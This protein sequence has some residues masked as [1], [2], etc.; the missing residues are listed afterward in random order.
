[1]AGKI[2]RQFIDDLLARTDIVEL[3]DARVNLKKAGK[4]YQACCPFHNEK[5]PS[6][7]VSQDKQFYHCFGCGANGNAIS[8]VMEYDKLDFVDAIEELAS[9][10]HLEV[11]REQ[12]HNNSERPPVSQEQK[13]SDYELMEQAA[14]YYQQQLRHHANSQLVIDYLKGRGLSGQTVK[15]YQIGYAPSEW[16]AL[17]QTLGKN[18]K[19]KQQLIELK[20]ATQ[21]D[22]GRTFDFFRDRLMFPIRDRRGRVIAFGGRIMGSDDN[23]PKYLNS[24]ETRVF[25]KGFEL[26]GFYEAKQAHKK[27]EQL[28]IVEGYMDVVALAEHDIKYAVAALGTAT[29]A[30]HM[31]LLLRATDKV[32]CC[33]DGDRAG[34]DAAWR[35]LEN[36][37][38]YLKDGK[39]LKFVFLPDG[40]D[41]DSLVQQEGKAAFEQRLGDAKD[42]IEVFFA[43]LSEHI[44][45]TQDAGKAKLLSEA[46]PLIEKIPSEFYQESLLERLARFIGRTREQLNAKLK[47]P[48]QQKRVE[49]QFK[50][51]PMRTAIAL[52]VQHPQLAPTV[53]YMPEL[54]SLGLPGLELFLAIQKQ[55]LDNPQITTAQ[56][57]ES[58]RERPEYGALTKLAA[59]PHQINDEVLEP[60]FQQ[61]VKFIEDQCLNHRLETLLIKDKTQGLSFEERREYALL[62]Q[63]LKGSEVLES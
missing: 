58:Y 28:L 56:L 35:A 37:L 48:K 3:I 19:Q 26:Y 55:C 42:F 25:H 50:M 7:T 18:P 21:K 29:T 32:I 17:C 2:P 53:E 52:M 14:R 51:T 47:T 1:M 30:E 57:L 15:D 44:D 6:F 49:S 24:P 34:R 36:A 38:P 54:A 39:A 10:L 60:H 13:R 31:Q 12:G 45:L 11:P 62:T 20:L 33:Y 8:F 59:W 41:P 23:G 9:L 27:L 16:E 63:A 5:T 43:R 46:L 61:T 40:E 4:D 22:N